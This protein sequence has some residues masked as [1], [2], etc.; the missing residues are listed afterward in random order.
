M[1]QAA[2]EDWGSSAI[3]P[4]NSAA[5]LFSSGSAFNKCFYSHPEVDRLYQQVVSAETI[6]EQQRIYYRT[7]AIIVRDA[8]TV[9]ICNPQDAIAHRKE[10][11]GFD[12]NAV[13][14]MPLE[15]VWLAN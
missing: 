10:V 1:F 5:T 4:D 12:P 15:K 7:E 13:N 8:P 3:N 9:W 2:I 11:K 14:R 6:E